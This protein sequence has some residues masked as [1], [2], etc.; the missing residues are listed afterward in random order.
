[1]F[2]LLFCDNVL[3]FTVILKIENID[4]YLYILKHDY[5]YIYIFKNDCIDQTSTIV[6]IIFLVV[7]GDLMRYFALLGS[8]KYVTQDS[9]YCWIL[10]FLGKFDHPFPMSNKE[11]IKLVLST[12]D[13]KISKRIM[14]CS[15]NLL[16]SVSMQTKS[17]IIAGVGTSYS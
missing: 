14:Y 1:M 5:I 13:A 2:L 9:H 16:T 3:P 17:F 10:C 4:I 8:C 6:S 11:D 15:S 12:S 7:S